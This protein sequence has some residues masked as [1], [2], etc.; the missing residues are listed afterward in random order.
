MNEHD[1][2]HG[3]SLV[4]GPGHTR[5]RAAWGAL[6]LAG[7]Q[8]LALWALHRAIVVGQWPADAPQVLL[9]A[10]LLALW[11]PLS[12]QVLWAERAQ[13]LMWRAVAI[14]AVFIALSGAYVGGTM[15]DA[16]AQRVARRF[17]LWPWLTECLPFALAW[18]IA[19]P[20]LRSRL[21]TGLWSAPYKAYFHS[22]WRMALTLIESTL[23]VVFFWA[24]LGLWGLLFSSLGLPVF[25]TLFSDARF[26]YPATTLAMAAA[27]QLIGQSD[28]LVDDVLHQLLSLLKWLAPLAACI[29]LLFSLALLPRLGAW[30][31]EGSR[32]VDS[33]W[34]LWLVAACVL[35][36]NAAYQDGARAAPWGPRLSWLMRTVPPLMAWVA[37]IALWSLLVRTRQ[38]GLTESRFWGLVTAV[39]GLA[40]GVGYSWAAWR[41]G[42]WMSRMGGV[43][44]IIALALLAVLVSSVTPVAHPVR[45]EVA[46]QRA[47]AQSAVSPTQRDQH[48]RHLRFES[49]PTG[50]RALQQ[51][52]EMTDAQGGSEALR[53]SA[54][55]ALAWPDAQRWA[56]PE[57]A[58]VARPYEDWRGA[59]RVVP[60]TVTLP[61]GLEEVLRARHA[62]QPYL[63]QGEG[64]APPA[65]YWANLDDDPAPEALLVL[66]DRRY[67]LWAQRAG[68]WQ[69]ASQGSL[70]GDE[71]VQA[72][73]RTARDEAASGSA[74]ARP[75]FSAETLNAAL[76]RADLGTLP[77]LWRDLRVGE[78]RLRLVPSA[79]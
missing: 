28:R 54:A 8:A 37:A 26:A 73:Q 66:R 6:V 14:G 38:Y 17:A 36:L 3:A 32:A 71:L 53:A 20:W 2:E 24:L 50:L 59:L 74:G 19:V 61:P 63:L 22:S 5:R 52:A 15:V 40:Y 55:A 56:R 16:D 78:H 29:L 64:N 27:L 51:L 9:P 46:S 11:V 72:D 4:Q 75:A 67:L 34:S 45:L 42:P 12:L 58:P 68:R 39:F 77:P 10:V 47:R 62:S 33:R 57:V 65:L 70:L 44:L 31:Q 60:S 41:S 1:M 30:W 13:P 76:G 7:L 18:S 21:Q 49:G 43:N 35:L 25:Q 69:L 48:L 79:P 23:F